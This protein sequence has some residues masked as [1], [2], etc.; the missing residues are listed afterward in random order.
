MTCHFLLGP[1]RQSSR[2]LNSALSACSWIYDRSARAAPKTTC[3]SRVRMILECTKVLWNSLVKTTDQ[4]VPATEI[5]ISLFR[6][7]GR[8]ETSKLQAAPHG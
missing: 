8:L 6:K 5:S 7:A 2:K 1:R 3:H 4:K